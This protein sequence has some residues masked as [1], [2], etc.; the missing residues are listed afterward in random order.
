[1]KKRK[2]NENG[3]TLVEVVIALTISAVIMV[4]LLSALRLG[5]RSQDKGLERAE[6]S[7]RMRIVSDRLGW[8]IRGAFPFL[9]EDEE[10]KTLYFQGA[11]DSLGLVTTSVD[12]YSD[13]IE[14]LAGLKWVYMFVDEE[15]LKIIEKVYFDSNI[16]DNTKG[17]EVLLDPTAREITFQY[18]DRVEDEETEEWVSAWDSNTKE[19]LPLA[20]RVEIVLDYKGKPVEMPPF[21]AAI[22]TGGPDESKKIKKSP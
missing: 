16:F 20:V 8:L 17:N 11:P 2:N 14:D 1:M 4:I 3:L 19:Y 21:A 15:G 13:T 18:L 9:V 6:L 10:G 5:H 7:Q 12:P 22:R